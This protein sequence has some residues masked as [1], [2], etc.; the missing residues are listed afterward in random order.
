MLLP[1][2][3]EGAQGARQLLECWKVLFLTWWC[4]IGAD[5]LDR[6]FIFMLFSASVLWLVKEVRQREGQGGQQ[7]LG[8]Y[9]AMQ[10]LVVIGADGPP[11]Q[12]HAAPLQGV[13]VLQDVDAGTLSTARG[14]HECSHLSW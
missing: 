6:S 4:Y 11:I 8:T 2:G 9:H 1:E 3:R 12:E 5:S 13:K 14:P 7:G 10:V